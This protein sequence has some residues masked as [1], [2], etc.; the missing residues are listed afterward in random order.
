MLDRLFAPFAGVGELILRL[1]LGLIFLPHGLP[2]LRS[3]AETAGLVGRI[4]MP[5]PSLFAWLVALLESVGAVLLIVGLLTRFVALGLAVDML[6]AIVA[7]RIRMSK[8]P[9]TS[10]PQAQ[11][12]EFEFALMAIALALV[13]MGGGRLALD[14]YLGL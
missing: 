9:F 6:V 2:K 11:G 13:F 3:P 5:A 10:T 12:W 4:G 1:A 14:R 7:V 8:A